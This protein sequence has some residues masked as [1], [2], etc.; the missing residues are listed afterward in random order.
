MP[1]A[2]A[3]RRG[4]MPLAS[5]NVWA[6]RQA[7]PTFDGRGVLLA[8]LDSGIDP[9][10]P[11]LGAT[12][13]GDP[14][15][16]D[17]RDFSAEGRV[18]LGPLHP[19]GDTVMVGRARLLGM[20]RVAALNPSGPWYGGALAE[21]TLGQLPAAD[22]DGDGT[23][24]DDLPLVVT[25]APEGWVVFADT[26]GDGSLG[27]ERPV[28]DYLHAR[29][30]FGWRTGGQAAPLAVAANLADS[31]GMPLLDLFFDT[32]SHGTH[33]A[34]IAAGYGLYGISGFDGVAPGAQ[35]LG[36]K[37]ANNAHGGISVTGSM[38]R[39]MDYAIRFARQRG[40]P[41]VMNLSFGVG[42]E[43]EG[44]AR[45]DA[46]VDSVLA[47]NP[48]VVFVTSAGND[49]PGISTLGFPASAARAI[50]VGATLPASFVGPKAGGDVVAFF[51]ARGG[52]LGKPDVMAPGI[53]FSSVPR[54][55]VGDEIKNG[56][57]MASPHVAGAAALLLSAARQ[58]G[59]IVEARQL[60]QALEASARPLPNA[61]APDQGAGLLDLM[62]ADRVLRRLPAIAAIQA[63]I[64]PGPPEP[65]PAAT[66]ANARGRY[67]GPAPD[68]SVVLVLEGGLAG[69]VRLQSDAGWL[70]VPPVAS[71]TPPLT[72]VRARVRLG[73][74]GEPGLHSATVTGW[75][76]DSTI[77]PIFRASMAVVRALA[78]PDS[79]LRSRAALSPAG[80]RRL[81]F[82]ADSARPVRVRVESTRRFEKGLAFLHEPGGQPNRGGT[83][84]EAGAGE[85]AAEFELDGRD[86]IPGA[87]EAVASALPGEPATLELTV[88]HAPVAF[89]ATRTHVDSV[90]AWFENRTAH[91]VAGTVMFGIQ[92]GERSVRFSQRGSAERRVPVSVPGWATRLVVDL[93]MPRSQWPLFTDLGFSVVD[94][95]GQILETEPLN[96][97]LGRLAMDLEPR[98]GGRQIEVVLT[99]GFADPGS[100]ALWEADLSIRFYAATP[101][102]VP[103]AG[104]EEI[105]LGPG[106]RLDRM[107]VLG[108]VPWPLGDGF[109]PVG[110]LV[111]DTE[112]TLWGREV[113]LPDPLPPLM[114]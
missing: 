54:W 5:T 88:R 68:S 20:S 70:V 35:L 41:L 45:I 26:N 8:I 93:A 83:G 76:S 67:H 82:I 73:L 30:T 111:L 9:A 31:A 17:L 90:R 107:L 10:V 12:S 92:G 65:P 60:K 62:A 114:R 33:V 105:R 47:A 16:L 94:D 27:D 72:R 44:A 75:A 42:N 103:Q 34:G 46:L 49:G 37:I 85:G 100:T 50:T 74:L 98:L 61:A 84:L 91:P 104:P 77:G 18:A 14:K 101:M 23:N 29:Q 51:S 53:A 1:A 86:L 89:G 24:T 52:E 7:N 81:F 58:E 39:A 64:E 63:W 48:D 109:F 6:Y 55:S 38:L 106:E 40:F 57:S 43:R 112:G 22:L 102:L 110:H 56:T 87:Y 79:G 28:Q 15:L 80:I 108:P 19:N 36:L 11:G 3:A 21:R 71:V 59:R 99:P 32:S 78:V 4:L 96:Y 69:P 25:R 2:E 113:P 95:E 13:T 66:G 97:A